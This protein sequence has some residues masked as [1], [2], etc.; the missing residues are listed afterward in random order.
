MAIIVNS[1]STS[2]HL[3]PASITVLATIRS[4]VTCVIAYLAT[5]ESTV[6]PTSTNA[7]VIRVY[8]AARATTMSTATSV[9]VQQVSTCNLLFNFQIVIC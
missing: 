5:P 9:C 3:T 4:M 2:A 8:T 1:T 7:R 6:K